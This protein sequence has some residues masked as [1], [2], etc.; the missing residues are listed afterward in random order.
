MD[1]S[2]IVTFGS[3]LKCN[4]GQELDTDYLHWQYYQILPLCGVVRSTLVDN[5]L[6]DAGFFG[7]GLPH[8]R[9]EAL[10]AMLNK[11]LM[12]YGCDTATGRFMQVSY[13]LFYLELGLLFQ[14]MQESDQKYSTLVT[15]SWMKMLW[16]KTLMF[17]LHT[18]VAD[19][20]FQFPRQ[21]DQS[22]MWVFI[23]AGYRGDTLRWLNRVR[24]SIQVLFLS[25]VLTASGG[26]VS[27]DIL[28][29]QPKGEVWSTMR[30][31][32]EWPTNSDMQLWNNALSSICPSRSSTSSIG[33][34]I[35][36][37]H[38]V[39]RWLWNKTDSSIH[40]VKPNGMT[41]DVFVV[42]HKPNQFLYSHSQACQKHN[43]ICSVQ[44]T[45]EGDHWR[46]LSTATIAPQAATL[47]T[48]VNVLKS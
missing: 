37:S 26:K 13:S 24:I 34:Y 6:I 3:R 12:H 21:G 28:S 41:E 1:I 9:V 29:R 25:N 16:E 19:V 22:L 20:P 44:P 40:H 31:P 2:T 38:R 11:L 14:P 7:V 35:C 15:H 43:A 23:T 30:W 45:L 47:C 18:V 4:F 33:E 42:G 36:N 46:L 10:I 5:R 48:F 27:L 8:L 39:Q 32:T 17:E